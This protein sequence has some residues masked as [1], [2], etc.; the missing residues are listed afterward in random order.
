MIKEISEKQ[1]ITLA[2]P[3]ALLRKAKVIAAERQTSLSALLTQLLSELVK[4]EDEYEQ[5]RQR[6]FAL[7]EQGFNLGTYGKISWSR[8]ELYER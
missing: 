7:M 8:D 2:V 3:K 6:S 1:N 5:A 4:Q